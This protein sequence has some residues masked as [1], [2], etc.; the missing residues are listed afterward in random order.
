MPENIERSM[1]AAEKFQHR[2][3]APKHR[4]PRRTNL[5]PCRW[6]LAALLS[7]GLLL[8]T[9][10]LSTPPLAAQT[11][12]SLV[13]RIEG[14]IAQL[15][16]DS[17]DARREATERL[18]EAGAPAAEIMA[19]ALQAGS[20]ERVMRGVHVLERI[21][22]S[23]VQTTRQ[24]AISALQQVVASPL[25]AARVQAQQTLQKLND[26]LQDQA[27]AYFQQRGARAIFKE[28]GSVA[29]NVV[30]AMNNTLELDDQWQ[31]TPEDLVQLKYLMDLQELVF[32]GEQ[33]DDKYL[34]QVH[35]APDMST[36]TIYHGK[37][38]ET[39][40]RTLAKNDTIQSLQI[41]YTPVADASADA[42]AEMKGLHTLQLY[43]TLVT[44]Q[45]GEKLRSKL[46]QTVVQVHRGGFLG[47]GQGGLPGISE[48]LIVG[49]IRPDSAAHKAD[50]QFGDVI[51]HVGDARIQSFDD[52]SSSMETRAHGSH[53]ML[54]VRRGAE[55][56]DVDVTLGQRPAQLFN[57][58]S[59]RQIRAGVPGLQVPAIIPN[60]PLPRK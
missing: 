36:L 57:L 9:G 60:V 40:L 19:D 13:G 32:V 56:L 45:A 29:P 41:R 10:F 14:W 43:G 42:L 39:G 28:F 54:K 3:H 6:L 51:T 59:A 31:G 18:I 1:A 24:S 58:M 17:F 35:H 20:R 33:F 30:F 21:A 16:S 15:D 55:T 4:G 50:L 26:W 52:L 53:V 22:Y 7:T 5:Y 11:D 12:A 27:I 8:S 47:V 46:P 25:P 38:T 23:E 49:E 44:E 34:E 37:I 48:G 2:T